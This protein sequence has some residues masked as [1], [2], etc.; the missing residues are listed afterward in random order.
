MKMLYISNNKLAKISIIVGFVF[1]ILNFKRGCSNEKAKKRTCNC[2]GC[3]IVNLDNG[4]S[5]LQLIS[6]LEKE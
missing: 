6:N 4:H 2:C 3:Y 5:H 1:L